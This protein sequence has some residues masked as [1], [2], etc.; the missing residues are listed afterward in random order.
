M[1]VREMSDGR[2]LCINQTS[3]ALLSEALCRHWGNHEFARPQPYDVVMTAIGQHDNG[4]HQWESAPKLRADGYPMDFIHEDDPLGKVDLWRRGVAQSYDQHP[5]SALLIG[6]H[7]A[8]LYEKYLDNNEPDVRR[9]ISVFTAEQAKLL[10]Q[11]RT[12]FSQT[13]FYT[14]ALDDQCIDANCRLLQFGDRASLQLGIPWEKTCSISL[15]PVD[16]KGEFTT[17]TMQWEQTGRRGHVSFDPWP[18][19]VDRFEVDI[20]G[21]LLSQRLFENVADYHMALKS[22]PYQRLTWSVEK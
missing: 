3:H 10:V 21:R 7:A 4:W 11:M 13:S 9:E 17:I 15:C 2:L 18:Y 1:I 14:A 19:S 20:H 8:L 12:D 16:G 6:R 22:A 5:Y